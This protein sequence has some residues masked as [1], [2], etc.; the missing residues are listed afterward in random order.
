LAAL[1]AP[2]PQAAA[3]QIATPIRIAVDRRHMDIGDRCRPDIGSSS[4]APPQWCVLLGVTAAG[5]DL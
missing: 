1:E 3:R 5:V 2:R 4:H